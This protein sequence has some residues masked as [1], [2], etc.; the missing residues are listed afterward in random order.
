MGSV[1][2]RRFNDLTCAQ[3]NLSRIGIFCSKDRI[4]ERHRAVQIAGSNSLSNSQPFDRADIQVDM[5]LSF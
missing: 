3:G 4:G 5:E 2:D 1:W